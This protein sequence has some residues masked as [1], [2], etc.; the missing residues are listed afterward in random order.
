M[1]ALLELSLCWPIHRRETFILSITYR[2]NVRSTF[3]VVECKFK[4]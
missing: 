2:Q 3:Q 1:F 4:S